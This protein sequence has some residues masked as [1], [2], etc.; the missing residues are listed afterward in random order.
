M[1]RIEPKIG[2]VFELNG[3]RYICKKNDQP[4]CFY[5]DV[6]YRDC[7]HLACGE[8]ERKDGVDVSFVE[9]EDEKEK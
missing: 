3:K 4:G 9:V 7:F 5:C 6:K 1:K 2:E 8:Y